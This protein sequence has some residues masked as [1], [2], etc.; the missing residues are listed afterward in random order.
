[1]LVLALLALAPLAAHPDS[2]S[3]SRVVVQGSAAHVSVRC[4]VLSLLE[5]V[6]GLDADGDGE[7]DAAEVAAMRAP[8]GAYVAEHYRL[9]VGTSRRMEGGERL[10][11]S[12]VDVRRVSGVD[13]A[14]AGYRMGAVD[15]ELVYA[16][17]EPILDLMVESSLFEETSP[18]HIDLATIEWPDGAAETFAL[19]ARAPRGRS[20]PTGRGA[21]LAFLGLGWHHIL[22]GWDHLA[23]LLAL[24][25][26]SR[27]LR[28]L[29]WV[30]TAFTLAHSVSLGLA[31]YRIVDV[32][33]HAG[34]VEA[35]IALSIAYVAAET[36]VQPH[37]R[38]SRWPEAFVFGLVH[39]LGFAGFLAQSLVREPSKGFALFSFNLGVE[40][41]QV[42]IVTA[43]TLA[44]RLLPRRPD[45]QDPFLAP[46][47]LRR[48][49][50]AIVAVLGLY[51]F[52]QRI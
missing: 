47:R 2:L 33:R 13:E 19:E 8:I 48:W 52:F 40:V 27:R 20:D 49:G 28:S 32:S 41:G 38:R 12:L 16:A 50:S 9:F 25:L 29:L 15:I 30:V 14:A 24:V 37:L 35:L 21:F 7:V 5:V 4:Q 42:L 11:S 26:A 36:L 22:S 51:W 23:F 1:M 44:L 46:A 10:A 43:A 18:G 39:G 6:D 17:E 45:E 3:S 34:F 31:T